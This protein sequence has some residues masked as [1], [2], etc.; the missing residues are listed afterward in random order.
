MN[1]LTYLN[2]DLA[3]RVTEISLYW[4]SSDLDASLKKGGAALNCHVSD[5]I[6][7]RIVK[8]SYGNIGLLQSLSLELFQVC[9]IDTEQNVSVEI[10]ELGALES[11]GMIY[12]AQLEAIY[13]KF[14][15]RVSKGIRQRRNS[16]KIYAHAMWAIFD[17]SDENLMNGVSCDHIYQV[18][19]KKESR[20]QKG[21]LRSILRKFD[22]LQVDEFGKGLVLTFDEGNDVVLVVDRTVLFFRR[23]QTYPWPWEMLATE[24]DDAQSN[25]GFSAADQ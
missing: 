14:A 11:A 20:I 19:H 8:D 4:S 21:N 1:Y 25:M 9:G 18:S 5:E 2:A 23:Y 17:C 24:E 16:T 13:T 6:R 22:E 3:G 15:E 10:S 12:A 7:E